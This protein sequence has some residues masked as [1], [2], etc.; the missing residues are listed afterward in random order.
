MYAV[1]ESGGKQYK[2]AVGD[3]VKVESLK[4]DPGSKL[5]LDKVLFLADGDDIKVGDPY[6]GG[7]VQATV[8]GHGR[9]EKIRIFKLR[10]RKNSR[11]RAGHRQNFTELEIVSI[12]GKSSKP[13]AKTTTAKK[14]PVKK[15]PA[16]AAEAAAEAPAADAKAEKTTAKKTT[17]KKTT[18][19]KTTVKKAAGK[20]TAAKKTA[21]KKTTKKTAAKKTTKKS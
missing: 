20:K 18:A 1:I 11:Q 5:D 17:T 3:R 10:R 9:G 12:N 2:V 13:A 16:Q 21:T 19:K 14:T 15:A 6:I 8:V 4:L 7:K